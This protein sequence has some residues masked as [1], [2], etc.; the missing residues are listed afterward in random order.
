M[1]AGFTVATAP[2]PTYDDGA[3]LDEASARTVLVERVGHLGADALEELYLQHEELVDQGIDPAPTP[4]DAV[5]RT[6]RRLVVAIERLF[7]D[8]HRSEL[9]CRQLGGRRWM[10]SGGMTDEDSPTEVFDDLVLLEASGVSEVPV[11][12][13][14]A[15]WAIVVSSG[16]V[17]ENVASSSGVEVVL[18]DFDE[19]DEPGNCGSDGVSLAV[20]SMF[21]SVVAIPV[22]CEVRP[23]AE[24]V[25][26]RIIDAVG[27][28]APESAEEMRAELAG[29][30]DAS[31]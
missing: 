22:E 12:R 25:A 28:R 21:E 16:G 14:L 26:R 29:V 4:A 19:L 17:V 27:S 15:G 1:S 8:E 23:F 2:W 7:G 10:L 6:R 30:A 18:V 24:Q 20:L 3:D 5:G 9:V 31:G 11:A 13:R